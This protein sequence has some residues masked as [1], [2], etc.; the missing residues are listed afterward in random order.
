M[1]LTPARGKFDPSPVMLDA[2]GGLHHGIKEN[3]C[4]FHEEVVHEQ[5]VPFRRRTHCRKI[6]V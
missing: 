5:V 1:Y 6:I 3:L 2:Q 4:S